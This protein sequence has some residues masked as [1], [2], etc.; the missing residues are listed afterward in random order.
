MNRRE[1]SLSLIAPLAANCL[2]AAGT[3]DHPLLLSIGAPAVFSLIDRAFGG[4]GAVPEPLPDAFPA[5]GSVLIERIERLIATRIAGVLAQTVHPLRRESDV[6]RLAGFT[7]PN[8]IAMLEF[9]ISGDRALEAWSFMLAVPLGTVN[10]LLGESEGTRKAPRAP[11]AADPAGEPFGEVP[12]QLRAVLVEVEVPVATLAALQ[13]GSILPVSVARK[14]PL[15]IAGRTIA[16]GAVG[17]LDDRAAL[18]ILSLA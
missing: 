13:V 4:R 12:L 14:V 2:L 11:S 5:S 7:L 3:A 17:E 15:R 8:R 9:T 10:E 6:A 16:H 18:Q 1:F